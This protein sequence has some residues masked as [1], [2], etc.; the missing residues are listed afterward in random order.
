MCITKKLNKK[1][2]VGGPRSLAFHFV[3]LPSLQWQMILY[4]PTWIADESVSTCYRTRG[5]IG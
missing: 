2:Q 3:S 4:K 5:F 1:I